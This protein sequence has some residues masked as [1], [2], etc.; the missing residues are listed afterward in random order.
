MVKGGGI[1]E[2]NHSFYLNDY[3][4]FVKEATDII[5]NTTNKNY[6]IMYADLTNFQLVND[7]YGFIE[8]DR[9]LLEFAEFLSKSPR[10]KLCG[11]VFSD[12]FLRLSLFEDDC[13]LEQVTSEYEAKLEE[14]ILQQEEFH[15]DSKVT[16]AAGLCQIQIMDQ[17]V[18]KAI[19]QANI[20]RKE[21]KKDN[22]CRL[23]WFNQAMQD[24]INNRK[25]REVEIHNALRNKLFTFYLQPKVNINTGKIV[26][27]EALARLVKDGKVIYPDQFIEIMEKNETIIDL[28]FL[29][30]EQVCQYLKERI[31]HH[32]KLIP[33]SMNMS[34]MHVYE[35]DFVNKVNRI[36][37]R[38]QIPPYLLEF[39]ITE[40]VIL[41]NLN[42]VR[43][44]ADQLRS[45][46]YRV[47][48]DDYGTGYSGMNIWQ[49]L[50]FDIVKL[51]RSYI[52]KRELVN[53]RNNIIIPAIVDICN[54]L[55]TT[56]VCEGVETLDQCLYMKRYGCNVVQGYYFSKPIAPKDFD[57][58]LKETDGKF[59]LPWNKEDFKYNSVDNISQSEIKAITNS[60]FNFIPGGVAGFSD[61]LE[62]L[63]VSDSLVELT[64]YSREELLTGGIDWPKKL[65]FS[66]EEFNQAFYH[67]GLD[68]RETKNLVEFKIKSKAGATIYINMY[69][70]MIDSPEWGTYY[71]C[72]FYDVTN[73]KVNE[74]KSLELQ[75]NINNLLANI[76]GGI[77]K[78]ALDESTKIL[79]ASEG[80]YKVIGYTR[81]QFHHAPINANLCE[82]VNNREQLDCVKL[83]RQIK[84]KKLDYIDIQIRSKNGEI[85]WLTLYF[86]NVHEE[87]NTVVADLFCIDSTVDHQQIVMKQN[88]RELEDNLNMMM[89]NTP[90]D[91]V[92]IE[93]K[94]MQIQTCFI[95]HGLAKSLGYEL[96]WFNDLIK[97]NYG[98]NFVYEDDREYLVNSFI[99]AAKKQEK[100]DF[101]YR[102]YLKDHEIS[103]HNLTASFF[104]QKADGTII[105]HGI[106]TCVDSLK[107]QQEHLEKLKN[108]YNFI[109]SIM[110]V[111]VW[112][113]DI[114]NNQLERMYAGDNFSI[115]L[116]INQL[117]TPNDFIVNNIILKE[118]EAVFIE[119]VDKIRS[120]EKLVHQKL[121]FKIKTGVYNLFDVV[122]R[123]NEENPDIAIFMA[124]NFDRFFKER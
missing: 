8:G 51:D 91:I 21:A 4:E 53:N 105:Y 23:I 103:W 47:S 12:H 54:K 93:V 30:C 44:V 68:K 59:D 31:D 56:I 100:I 37:E 22:H 81:E 28:D 43:S 111:D 57:Q 99:K 40:T 82:I 80:F 71:L 39:E 107:K 7:F 33:V 60:I 49:D 61:E 26:G 97:S 64:G 19:D 74:L 88:Y 9:F 55:Q 86:S 10:T 70:G 117:A 34:R 46:G 58:L 114:K 79:F 2:E 110:E 119:M 15:P 5:Y 101:D 116:S 17:A 45:Y 73:E 32:Q 1:M 108:R 83:I 42:K 38:Y 87:A 98:L 102:A 13:D 113:Y 89:E 11:R 50:N 3:T 27:S 6:V 122:I 94:D 76:K 14:F 48:I 112:S 77:A 72:C 106:V 35:T 115:D 36:V 63:F 29:I 41:K 65:F 120:G 109:L 66:E 123:V 118:E 69:W 67:N 96:N 121:H 24:F 90:G 95:T 52:L 75:E 124:K 62:L 84:A 104:Q 16:V 85:V 18:I 78:I 20:A 92:V 25:L